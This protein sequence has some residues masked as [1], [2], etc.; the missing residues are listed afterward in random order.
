MKKTRIQ[1]AVCTALV[2]LVVTGTNLYAKP[3]TFI[4][5]GLKHTTIVTLDVTGKTATGT[6]FETRPPEEEAKPAI[7]FTGK[8]IPT[9]KGKRGVYLEIKFPGETPYN[10]PPGKGPLI[11]RLKIVDH[12]AH[13][14]IPMIMRSYETVPAKHV[15]TDMELESEEE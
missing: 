15:L 14:F 8:V 6:Y 2:A 5:G 3:I 9:P 11:W 13:L 1:I 7:S 10:A 12:R 4:N